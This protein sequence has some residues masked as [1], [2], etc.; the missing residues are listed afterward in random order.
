MSRVYNA[1]VLVSYIRLCT[2]HTPFVKMRSLTHYHKLHGSARPI[3]MKSDIIRKHSY[4]D[5]HASCTSLTEPTNASNTPCTPSK[6]PSQ[7][8]TPLP[9][10]V[11][12]I[13]PCP[14]LHQSWH[15]TAQPGL[16][17]HTI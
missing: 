11:S 17:P 4:H 2:T 6:L 10:Q 3:I 8:Q 5:A 13:A 1:C 15:R 14:L 9:H 16:L 12:R 7:T